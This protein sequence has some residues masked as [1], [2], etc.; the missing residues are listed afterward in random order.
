MT[1]KLFNNCNF[2]H[3]SLLYEIVLQD[4]PCRFKAMKAISKVMDDL[5]NFDI[6]LGWLNRWKDEKPVNYKIFVNPKMKLC[7]FN[8][9]RKNWATLIVYDV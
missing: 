3:N 5:E 6:Q 7:G 9:P 1:K 4:I 8:L 2:H